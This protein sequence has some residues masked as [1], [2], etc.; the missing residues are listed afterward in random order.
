MDR[1]GVQTLPHAQAG[2]LP[3]GLSARENLS[4]K[5]NRSSLIGRWLGPLA[6]ACG[7]RLSD[8]TW[9]PSAYREGLATLEVS[10]RVLE[11][12]FERLEPPAGKAGTGWFLG[13][14]GLATVPC[15]PTEGVQPARLVKI[16]ASCAG[17]V[18]TESRLGLYSNLE[19]RLGCCRAATESGALAG[20]NLEQR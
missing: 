16:W 5:R 3:A 11:G 7:L 13:G 8:R 12:A 19:Y 4:A 15:Y 1:I 6:R 14:G 20:R 17:R 18:G 2:R 9:S 10:D